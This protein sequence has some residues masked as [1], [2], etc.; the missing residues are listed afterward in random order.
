MV[1]CLT[2]THGRPLARGTAGWAAAGPEDGWELPLRYQGR[3][4]PSVSMGTPVPDTAVIHQSWG[5]SC[6]SAFGVFGITSN[7]NQ[8]VKRPYVR[9]PLGG[10]LRAGGL[11]TRAR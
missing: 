6:D 10:C 3:E 4:L 9:R 8:L 5:R 1:L 2:H 11:S 7:T